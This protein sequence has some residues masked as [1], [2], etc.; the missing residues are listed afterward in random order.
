VLKLGV[1]KR[2]G[3]GSKICP[4]SNEEELSVP[5]T[6]TSREDVRE[7]LRKDREDRP[8]YVSPSRDI[9]LKTSA[10]LA[11]L[12]K[13]GCSRP[14]LEVTNLSATE[15]E[16]REAWELYMLQTQRGYRMKEGLCEGRIV[17]D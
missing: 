1:N 9:F 5:H 3:E 11:A 13:L 4:N 8:Q 7:R 12:Q 17:F 16:A 6:K 15:E 10:Y 2:T 14:L